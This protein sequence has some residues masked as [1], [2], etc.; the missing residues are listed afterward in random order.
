VGLLDRLGKLGT[1]RP[2]APLLARLG[3]T[4]VAI[5]PREVLFDARARFGKAPVEA[6]DDLTRILALPRRERPDLDEQRA[7][8]QSLTRRLEKHPRPCGC[9]I[10][11]LLPI[12]GWYLTEAMVT[13]GALGHLVVGAGKTG[14]GILLPMVLPDVRTA[15]LLIPTALRAQFAH[16]YVEWSAHF[17][18]P[19]LAGGRTFTPGR[20]VLHVLAYSELSHEKCATWLASVR[21]DLIIADEVQSI[22]DK[23]SVRT[24][25]FLRYF[26][27]R[28]D[29]TPVRYAC[30][31]GTLTTNSLD[32]YAHHAAL[33]LREGSPLP[34]ETGTVRA[35]CGALDPS[36][37]GIPAP[38][39]ALRKLCVPGETA[40]AGFRRRLVETPGVI[41]TEDATLPVRLYLGTR[42]PPPAPTAVC[43]ALAFVREHATRPDG[44]EFTEKTEVVACL[45]QIASGFFY[46]W[47]YPRG[48]PEELI[49]AWFAR[50]KAWF[51]ELRERMNNRTDL[52]DSPKLLRLAAERYTNEYSGE[53]PTWAS[54][55]WAPWAEIREQV[56]PSTS[57]VWLSDWLARDAAAWGAQAPGVIW[58]GHRAFGEALEKLS[59]FPRFGDGPEASDGIRAEKGDR[60]IIASIRAHGTGKN[61]QNWNRALVTSVSSD[62]GIWEQLLGR[63]HRT[64]QTQDVRVWIYQHTSELQDALS[65][66]RERARYV[67]E[68]VG[69]AERLL[70]AEPLE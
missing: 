31:S 46:R 53:A 50:R 66:A 35:W 17:H 42:T 26:I 7:M 70:F 62:G 57:T 11:T 47:I 19:N 56:A 2:T 25:R 5:D 49:L 68:T 21:P 36:P 3:L 13:G 27:E 38:I 24:S 16:D 32:Q 60:T 65:D 12:Q 61:L 23:T 29:S 44:E 18:T 4:D 20:P 67:Q 40:R 48:E 58:Y 54:R 41:T 1:A 37:S 8:A 63:H 51:R 22:A 33:A 43:E 59:G 69:K 28:D 55:A 64:G 34:L 9:Q 6:S 30:H 10:H 39:G 45:R 15:V 52:L 14:L